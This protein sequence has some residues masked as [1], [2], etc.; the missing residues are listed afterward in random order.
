MGH[1]WGSN[2]FGPRHTPHPR[3]L[4]RI[5]RAGACGCNFPPE[6]DG[7]RATEGQGRANN[8]YH[9]EDGLPRGPHYGG[10]PAP[11]QGEGHQRRDADGADI[12]DY[13]QRTGFS[14]D[15]QTNHPGGA[16]LNPS[17]GDWISVG[18][19]NNPDFPSA[20]HPGT[21]VDVHCAQVE[22]VD[23]D[24]YHHSR[25]VSP[26]ESEGTDP[27]LVEGEWVANHGRGVAGHRHGFAREGPPNNSEA[28][29]YSTKAAYASCEACL[30]A[31]RPAGPSYAPAE[32]TYEEGE[33]P[34]GYWSG[35]I[36]DPT[37]ERFARQ[38]T[39]ML[40][41][42]LG[43]GHDGNIRQYSGS[44]GCR[45]CDDPQW[46]CGDEGCVE[47]LPPDGD[48][49]CWDLYDP[50][51]YSSYWVA[52]R[53]CTEGDVLNYRTPWHH[54]QYS[55]KICEG[56][57]LVAGMNHPTE[58]GNWTGCI[59]GCK[60]AGE[61]VKV[62]REWAWQAQWGCFDADGLQQSK[63]EWVDSAFDVGRGVEGYWSEVLAWWG[64]SA[65]CKIDCCSQKGCECPA[66]KIAGCGDNCCDIDSL[67]EF[68]ASPTNSINGP[69]WEVLGRETSA[70]VRVE[71]GTAGGLF[72]EFAQSIGAEGG[73][74]IK[75]TAKDSENCGGEGS[76]IQRGKATRMF[77]ATE[78]FELTVKM[79]TNHESRK[80]HDI[81]SLKLYQVSPCC[82]GVL[83]VSGP[84]CESLIE[85]P[86]EVSITPCGCECKR[87]NNNRWA[88]YNTTSTDG[89]LCVAEDEPMSSTEY[90]SIEE[91]ICKECSNPFT[92]EGRRLEGNCSGACCAPGDDPTPCE[93]MTKNECE[94][95]GWNYSGEDISCIMREGESVCPY[96][97][98]GACCY[99]LGPYSDRGD[100]HD[101]RGANISDDKWLGSDYAPDGYPC[102]SFCSFVLKE[103]CVGGA[104]RR[105]VLDERVETE[106]WA[107]N[108]G[109]YPL[110]AIWHGEGTRCA[111]DLSPAQLEATGLEEDQINLSWVDSDGGA[112]NCNPYPV[113][114]PVVGDAV[115]GPTGPGVIV[116]IT[117]DVKRFS[118]RWGPKPDG[119]ERIGEFGCV[120][121]TRELQPDGTYIL[122]EGWLNTWTYI[123]THGANGEYSPALLIKN[124]SGL[125]W[126]D[127]RLVYK[128]GISCWCGN[129]T[130]EYVPTGACC[131]PGYCPD[132]GWYGGNVD[133]YGDRCTNAESEGIC[134]ETALNDSGRG[135]YR[136]PSVIETWH[137]FGTV[138]E[139]IG[140]DGAY[141]R[142][143]YE[144]WDKDFNPH[145]CH[146]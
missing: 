1:D 52:R 85:V 128:D 141:G 63:I 7:V 58:V 42:D 104:Q 67:W 39:G 98:R 66:P 15:Q 54:S 102:G 140:G 145:T 59:T 34:V 49:I 108:G 20:G 31:E 80:D 127:P 82:G 38:R 120:T 94:E 130:V 10:T 48:G 88:A 51:D 71:R 124:D 37:D 138:C 6:P 22:A 97:R 60:H 133:C 70:G 46:V 103:V 68:V 110:S 100:A 27:E 116:A 23:L 109:E 114:N 44:T 78:D 18:F 16:G 61:C 99:T 41:C 3:T 72:G 146:H 113:H 76:K 137:G 75:Y 11:L 32:Y 125:A 65:E 17:V 126:V 122:L 19:F 73:H 40:R 53:L 81:A 136:L 119:C 28:G 26:E 86:R 69:T 135:E 87:L 107:A 93:V 134:G 129:A 4:L 55:Q 25:P 50:Y 57:T 43:A 62:E 123:A 112:H 64:T 105:G 5:T 9:A 144:W 83:G 92:V 12:S 117:F 36:L 8:P 79:L 24:D 30:A 13:K 56:S 47:V 111:Q 45:A 29:V 106:W 118:R 77:H 90:E 35:E 14:W 143:V 74:R 89:G 142:A 131:T 115:T 84:S 33:V 21:Y 101:G 139:S 95:K 132:T 96:D 121:R 91:C 2:K